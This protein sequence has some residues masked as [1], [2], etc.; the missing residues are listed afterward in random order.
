MAFSLKKYDIPEE[1]KKEI[2][3]MYA[4]ESEGYDVQI[5]DLNKK[6]KQFADYDELKTKV[7]TYETDMEKIKSESKQE[8]LNVKKQ[9]A[10]N[11][12]IKS[13]NVSND[14]LVSKL[15]SLDELTYDEEKGEFT[16]FSDKLKNVCDEYGIT[17]DSATK[18]DVKTETKSAP[19]IKSP[20]MPS[21]T[22]VTATVEKKSAELSFVEKLAQQK[23]EENERNALLSAK[24]DKPVS[25]MLNVYRNQPQL[26]IPQKKGT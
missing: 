5:K 24:N 20:D 18:T 14:K 7:T 8:L 1:I 11:S 13:A 2:M 15:L 17:I 9:F 21:S 19:V 3:D 6:V 23:R 16:D 4:T 22:K 10:Y 26:N 12:A 25:P